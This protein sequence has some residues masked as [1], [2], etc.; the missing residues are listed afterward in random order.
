M[1]IETVKKSGFV[2]IIESVGGKFWTCGKFYKTLNGARR[3]ALQNISSKI[4]RQNY[5]QQ[6]N[7]A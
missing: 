1:I 4:W 5:Q 2:E 6:R 3:C 7:Q